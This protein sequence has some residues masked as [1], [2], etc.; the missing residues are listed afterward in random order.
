MTIRQEQGK[1]HR[2]VEELVRDAFWDIYRPGCCEHLVVHRLRD[3]GCFIKE[4][5]LVMEDQGKII[6][7]VMY[8]N[9]TLDADD[10]RSIDV[11]TFGPVSIHPAYQG[12]GLGVKLIDH[13]LS[14]AKGLGIKAVFIEGDPAFYQRCGF[15]SADMYGV[16][17][18]EKRTPNPYFLAKELSPG[19]LKDKKGIYHTPRPYFVTDEDVEAYDRLF[20]L[21]PKGSPQRPIRQPTT[22]IPHDI[23][24]PQIT[25][26]PA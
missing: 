3:D 15:C 10:G 18:N 2:K 21:R 11:A 9:A 26:M 6:G 23:E 24:E 13:S 12:R 14:M 16:Y 22:C 4:L 7:Q 1:E 25:P 20:P 5:D 19:F 8:A 17:E